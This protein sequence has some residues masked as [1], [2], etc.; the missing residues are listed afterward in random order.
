MR[1]KSRPAR[2]P[3]ESVGTDGG[4]QP[5][6]AGSRTR[7]ALSRELADFLIEFSIVLHKRSMYPAGH[8]HLNDSADRFVRRMTLLLETRES[9]TL[10]V[11]RHRL[12]IDKVTTDANNALLRDLAH[13]LHRH[14]IASVHLAR[15]ASLSEIDSLL[16][17]LS[18]DPQRGEGPVGKRLTQIGPWSHIRLRPLGYDRLALSAPEGDRATSA[19]DELT[20]RDSWVELAQLAMASEAGDDIP[21]ADPVAVAQAIGRKSGEVAYD[22]VVLGYLARVA[23]EMSRRKGGLHDQLASRISKLIGA[24]NPETL[25]RLL[26]ASADGAERRQFVLNA[27]QIL[28]ADAV[29]E[30]VE[31]AAQASD[32]TISHN[33]LRLLHKLAHHA[34]Q[35]RPDIRA[36]ADGALRKNVARLIGDWGLEDPNPSE[37]NA[38]L[39]GMVQRASAEFSLIN[40]QVG[41][42]PEVMIKMALELECVG[43]PVFAAIEEL[44]SRRELVRI[45]SYLQS[46]PKTSASDTI[47]RYLAT[48]ERLELELV[49]TPLDQEA[50]AILVERIGSDAAGSLLDRLAT[51]PDRSTRA[52]VMKQLLALGPAVGRLAVMRLPD[53]P[54]Y[55]QRNILLLLG[56]LG[57]WPEGFS[58][59]PYA[60]S[61]DARIRREALKL[62]LDSPEHQVDA[63]TKALADADDGIVKLGLSAALEPCPPKLLPQLRQIA[64]DPK[65]PSD[66]RVL[67][68]R[69]I[70]RSGTPAALA[71]LCDVTMHRRRWLWRR[72]APKSPELLAA[73]SGLATYWR[74]DPAAGDALARALQHSDPDIRAA[75]TGR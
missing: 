40:L 8:P 63:L 65:R 6:T 31:A 51:A 13:R 44:L 17:A 72:L 21:E 60:S 37:Y 38:I 53:V 12:V 62:M 7:T 29:M 28:A 16:T 75:A 5:T 58:P 69:I 73:L 42:D 64:A 52:T 22:R 66:T 46:G 32:Q 33:L 57:T 30:V 9:V 10:G 11:A 36:E 39:E 49:A 35:G 26:E 4:Q 24:L 71:L 50:V 48:P 55:V 74:N 45:A 54:W 47:W 15:G 41:C 3:R 56:R 34:E 70:A 25:R 27:S 23:D 14:R 2:R 18:S 68:I 20:P 19:D 43:P 1:R 67:A 61:P 59:V